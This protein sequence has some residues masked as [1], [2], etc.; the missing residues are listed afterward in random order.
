L[1]TRL[2]RGCE[3][4]ATPPRS[5][6]MFGL[7][8]PFQ[9]SY[10]IGAEQNSSNFPTQ[11][12]G[13]VIPCRQVPL[14]VC[15]LCINASVVEKLTIASMRK[16]STPVSS[17]FR[18][19]SFAVNTHRLIAKGLPTAA[20]QQFLPARHLAQV[21][22]DPLLEVWFTPSSPSKSPADD[23]LGSPGNGCDHKPPD[24]RT[25]RLGKSEQYS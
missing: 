10:V 4:D 5:F 9:A 14:I 12:L 24:E 13:L 2:V 25:L 18:W 6:E 8:S 23:L 21:R 7:R 1:S 20:L 11:R 19:K 17:F 16:L 22:T 3:H 15:N